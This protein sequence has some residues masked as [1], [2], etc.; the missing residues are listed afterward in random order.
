MDSGQL[1]INTYKSPV[2]AA[3]W[4][5]LMPGFGQFYVRDYVHGFLLLAIELGLNSFSNLNEVIPLIV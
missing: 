4:S 2:A 1:K 5:A 3:L